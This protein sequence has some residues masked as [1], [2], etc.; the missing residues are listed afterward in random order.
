[1]PPRR[2]SAL[3]ILA[4][5]AAQWAY[6]RADL[7]F[8]TFDDAWYLEESFRLLDS[9]RTG[10]FEFARTWAGLFRFKAPLIALLPLPFYA[11]FG[12]TLDAALL[13]NV[14]ATLVLGAA[15][16]RLASRL[17][18]GRSGVFAVA[19]LFTF[20]LLY[21][22]SRRYYVEYALAA[23]VS[24]WVC[25]LEESDGLRKPA[26][27]LALGVLLGL[28]LLLKITFPLYVLGPALLLT[29]RERRSW[30]EE[31]RRALLLR[32]LA[33]AA[34]IAASWYAFNWPFIA[35]F[36]W[37]ASFGSLARQY[38]SAAPLTQILDSILSRWYGL[39]LIAA[40]AHWGSRLKAAA[41]RKGAPPATD[42]LLPVV[43]L[44]PPLLVVLAAVNRDIRYFAPAL[45][46][47]A[48]LIAGELDLRLPRGLPGALVFAFLLAPP[49]DMFAAQTLGRSFFLERSPAAY[50]GPPAPEPLWGQ[51]RFAAWVADHPPGRTGVV[52]VAL[53]HPALN[54]NNLSYAAAK[55]GWPLRFISLGYAQDSAEKALIHMRERGVDRAVFI[56]GLPDAEVLASLN[57]VNAETR[58]LLDAGRLGFKRTDSFE[59]YPGVRSVL[60]SRTPGAGS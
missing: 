41:A 44:L 50:N 32:V 11:L 9:L 37:R 36:A 40:L 43:W 7:A 10:A 46:A 39:L 48:L 52:V 49:L 16:F 6:I 45:P 38:T 55:N 20:P 18:G 22:L 33:P 2:A 19:V 31:R 54:A 58:A 30:D 26:Q 35:G 23:A 25:L 34:L 57:R 53:E 13:V 8:P 3:I 60:Y 47:A 29:W 51:E 1:M 12:R 24:A 59:L 28:G 56:E 14:L 17:Y 27:T 4:F 42:G 5:A 15:V 21:G